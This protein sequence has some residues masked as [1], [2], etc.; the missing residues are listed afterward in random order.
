MEVTKILWS[1]DFI[2]WDPGKDGMFVL[3]W[4]KTKSVDFQGKEII[5]QKQEYIE[6]LNPKLLVNNVQGPGCPWGQIRVTDRKIGG[7][8]PASPVGREW[9]V[10]GYGRPAQSPFYFS[11][12]ISVYLLYFLPP[13]WL[14][15]WAITGILSVR[16]SWTVC[17]AWLFIQVRF[18]YHTCFLVLLFPENSKLIVHQEKTLGA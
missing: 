1:Y 14:Y 10:S 8:Q 12:T 18:I 5:L 2:I 6:L 11:F 3:L 16:N 13:K 4:V 15:V 9:C 7:A 17:N